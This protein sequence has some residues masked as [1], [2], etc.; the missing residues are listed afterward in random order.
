M[1]IRNHEDVQLWLGSLQ[2]RFSGKVSNL[3]TY[4]YNPFLLH[5]WLLLLS[6][7]CFFLCLNSCGFV[8]FAQK[9]LWICLIYTTNIKLYNINL[10]LIYQCQ[11]G[12]PPEQTRQEDPPTPQQSVILSNGLQQT[13]DSQPLPSMSLDSLKNLIEPYSQLPI[14]FFLS[15]IFSFFVSYITL[16]LLQ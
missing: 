16:M 2:K 12:A 6:V 13:S 3:L 5:M 9:K 14:I 11:F 4:F 10:C 15:L 7:W 1:V 8:S